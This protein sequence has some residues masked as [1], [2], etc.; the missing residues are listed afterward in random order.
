MS[1][2]ETSNAGGSEKVPLS[3]VG[4]S[5]KDIAGV[6]AQHLN[7]TDLKIPHPEKTGETLPVFAMPNGAGHLKIETLKAIQDMFRNRPE[8]RSGTATLLSLDSFIAHANRFK[9]ENSALFAVNDMEDPSITAVLDYHE[10]G[11]GQPRF[12]RHRSLYQFPLSKQWKKWLDHNEEVMQS[13]DFAR[14][15]EDQIID[16]MDPPDFIHAAFDSKDGV[17]PNADQKL[18]ELMANVDG[19]LATRK[20]LL[21]LSRGLEVNVDSKVRNAQNLSTGEISVNWDE[22][23]VDGAGQPIKV[24]NW[25]LIGIPVFDNGVVY[26]LP[27]RLRYRI[28]AG[29]VLWF[30]TMHRPDLAFEDAFGEAIRKA[31]AATALPLMLGNPE[32]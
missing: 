25:F 19:N 7:P 6:L 3:Q 15:L 20:K 14:F 24:P 8:R 18:A 9:D 16:V 32:E 28:A 11:A 26:R 5:V 12:G 29:K 2:P 4:Q 1:K 10:A 31:E 22:Q 17:E 23:H 21:E 27:V 13:G 30:Y